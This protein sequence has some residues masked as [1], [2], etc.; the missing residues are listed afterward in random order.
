MYRRTCENGHA[1]LRNAVTGH[2]SSHNAAGDHEVP[3]DAEYAA[4]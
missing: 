2:D 4:V 1:D 3:V